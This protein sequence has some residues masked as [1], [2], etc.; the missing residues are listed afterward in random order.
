MFLLTFF[1]IFMI[2][3]F[4]AGWLY[5]VGVIHLLD[6]NADSAGFN[7]LASY[8]SIARH[9]DSDSDGGND[10]AAIFNYRP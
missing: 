10:D 7:S 8:M 4:D 5:H 3:D 9:T 2:R 6:N 1:Q